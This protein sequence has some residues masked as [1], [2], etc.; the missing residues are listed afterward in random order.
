MANEQTQEPKEKQPTN[1]EGW[2]EH[3]DWSHLNSLE[4][5]S[6]SVESIQK[7]RPVLKN[8]SSLI[9]HSGTYGTAAAWHDLLD[10]TTS[11]M[12]CMSLKDMQRA[13]F[14]QTVQMI[15]FRH[16][17]TLTSLSLGESVHF[18][19]YYDRTAETNYV[20]VV[21]H[22]YLK[23]IHLKSLAEGCPKLNYLDIDI[24]R[25]S[26]N[27][28]DNDALDILPD[29]SQLKTLTLR[30]ESPDTQCRRAHPERS[31]REWELQI[32]GADETV[33]ATS[34]IA[35]FHNLREQQQNRTQSDVPALV[36]LEVVVGNGGEGHPYRFTPASQEWMGQWK[37]TVNVDGKEV[38][39]G[40]NTSQK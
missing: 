31:E 17:A 34:M 40:R 5:S 11:S 13:D 6:A 16:G 21:P 9:V 28:L 2:L 27:S 19:E 25:T 4:L 20:R 14:D 1:L 7:L 33:N 30:V 15:V 23:P 24:N 3:M 18:R 39:K 12:T 10:N 37:C 38:C 8:L 22:V 32:V 29:F 26:L 35:L 36:S